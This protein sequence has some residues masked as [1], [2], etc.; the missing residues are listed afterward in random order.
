MRPKGKKPK[1][2]CVMKSCFNIRYQDKLLCYNHYQ[3][4]DKLFTYRYK[5]GDLKEV[6]KITNKT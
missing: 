4:K 6:I 1:N 5:Y 3:I 2:Y